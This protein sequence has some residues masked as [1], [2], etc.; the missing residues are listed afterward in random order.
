MRNGL[1]LNVCWDLKEPLLHSLLSSP[2]PLSLSCM[3]GLTGWQSWERQVGFVFLGTTPPPLNEKKKCKTVWEKF[4]EN[5]ILSAHENWWEIGYIWEPSSFPPLLFF[6]SKR[7]KVY[8]AVSMKQPEDL[9][10]KLIWPQTFSVSL[11]TD[12]TT[13]APLTQPWQEDLCKSGK[14]F[15]HAAQ[16][17]LGPAFY[18]ASHHHYV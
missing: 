6:F 9:Q 2:L 4:T 15:L 11:I 7:L 12:P 13:T 17:S 14:G 16:V 10:Q 3:A 5:P 8:F 1:Y 18:P